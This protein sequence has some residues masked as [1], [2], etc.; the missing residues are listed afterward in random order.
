MQ[1]YINNGVQ[2]GWLFNRKAK[3]VEIYR[4]GQE[5]DL[6]QEPRQL[7]GEPI[8]SNFVLSLENFW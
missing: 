3:Q 5:P 1:E 7:S 8:L 6:Q 2:L 4:L